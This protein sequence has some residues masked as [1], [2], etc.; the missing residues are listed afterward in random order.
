MT[1]HHLPS[2]LAAG[3][4]WS[5]IA[6]QLSKLA[7]LDATRLGALAAGLA[8]GVLLVW[9]YSRGSNRRQIDCS[10]HSP[11]KLFAELCKAHRLTA[12]QRRLLEWLAAERQLLQPALVFLDPILLESAIAHADSPGVR[13]RLTDLRT[14]LFA[15]LETT[16]TNQPARR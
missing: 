4:L 12:A 16:A 7:A 11:H 15:A 6:A 14:K 2:L 1:L 8:I 3:D 5:G 9:C 13:K 10:P